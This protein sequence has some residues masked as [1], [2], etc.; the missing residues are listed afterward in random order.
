MMSEKNEKALEMLLQQRHQP[1]PPPWLASRI[2]SAAQATPQYKTGLAGQIK[3][4]LEQVMAVPK[5]AAALALCL[6]IGAFAGVQ[7]EAY[8]ALADF[9]AIGFLYI[10]EDWI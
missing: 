3:F 2:I 6:V 7:L 8:L 10:S 5:P 9:D 4:W 1:E